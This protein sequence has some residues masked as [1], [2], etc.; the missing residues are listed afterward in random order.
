M[1]GKL[2]FY[3]AVI[4][5]TRSEKTRRKRTFAIATFYRKNKNSIHAEI[6]KLATVLAIF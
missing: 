2:L 3:S 1:I 5:L 6:F 4:F